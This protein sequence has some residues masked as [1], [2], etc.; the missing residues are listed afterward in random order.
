MFYEKLTVDNFDFGEKLTVDKGV[1]A[2]LDKA[3]STTDFLK[4]VNFSLFTI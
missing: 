2:L 4:T 1:K 3:L